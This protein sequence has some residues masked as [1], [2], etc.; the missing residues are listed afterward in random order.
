MNTKTK[1]KKK[2]KVNNIKESNSNIIKRSEKKILSPNYLNIEKTIEKI[3]QY[4]YRTN[5]EIKNIIYKKENE[6]FLKEKEN[7]F[8]TSL[9]RKYSYS[10]ISINHNFEEKKGNFNKLKINWS[11]K[12]LNEA[13]KIK[14]KTNDYVNQ[15]NQLNQIINILF[16]YIKKSE[17]EF[18]NKIKKVYLEKNDF[19]KKLEIENKMLINENKNLK[20]KLLELFYYIKSY[21]KNEMEIN[22]KK[23]KLY[24]QIIKENIYLRKSNSLIDKIDNS[25]LIKLNNE[26]LFQK[27]KKLIEKN[28]NDNYLKLNNV[29]NNQLIFEN[30]NNDDINLH[31]R[32]KTVFFNL[33]EETMNL[34]NKSISSESSINTIINNNNLNDN[35]LLE[36]T[37]KEMTLNNKTLKRNKNSKRNILEL[38]KKNLEINNINNSLNSSSKKQQQL[39][40]R[41]SKEENKKIL[42]TK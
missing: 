6:I 29:N 19:I 40:Y 13:F 25:L 34:N 4:S 7:N 12:N 33:N 1:P 10:K 31:K 3:P 22:N 15:I 27:E 18:Y 20:L 35:D 5:N 42:F 9:N 24:S 8:P 26:V 14:E 30:I 23:Q 36:D 39:Y 32:Q 11:H 21:E 38:E 17:F 16:F 2:S 37:L 41:L 28:I